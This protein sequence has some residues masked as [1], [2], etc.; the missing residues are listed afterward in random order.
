MTKLIE[1]I[2]GLLDTQFPEF[3]VSDNPNFVAF[4]KAYY[5]WLEDSNNGAVL[6][7]TKNLLAYK[8]IDSTTDQFIQYFINDFLP[9]FPSE[10]IA[11]QR[12]LVKFARE[13]YQTKGS[14]NSIKFLFRTLY[15]ED[16]E[17]FYP[18]DNILRASAGKWQ[19]PQSVRVILNSAYSES[20]NVGSSFDVALLNMRPALGSESNATCI[21]E[22]ALSTIDP[23]LG[24]EIVE[25]YVSN[26]SK[27]FSAE[28]YLVVEGAY[29]NT[30]SFTFKEKIIGSL[31]NITIN[32]N[33]KGLT[34]NGLVLNSN[35]SIAYPGDPV[36]IYGGL[37]NSPEA[38]K[39]IA[40]VNSV[41][42]GSISGVTV[43]SGG[44]GYTVNPNTIVT[45]TGSGSGANLIVTSVNNSILPNTIR[46]STDAIQY[47]AGARI[48]FYAPSYS[49]NLTAGFGN[50]TSTVNLNT[51]TY[52]ANTTIDNFYSQYLLQVVDG[53][54]ALVS[55]N[56]A[57]IDTYNSGTQIAT[58]RTPLGSALDSTSNV[59]LYAAE[60]YGLPNTAL[61]SN[62]L[63]GAG[64]T[65]T[66][67]NLS[68]LTFTPS[69]VN[70]YYNNYYLVV[71]GGT[72]A[73]ANPNEAIITSYNGTTKIATV[74]PPLGIALDGSSNVELYFSNQFSRIS[75][76]LSFLTLNVGSVTGIG[77][78]NGGYNFS[79]VPNISLSST[80]ETDFSSS[81][82]D[83]LVIPNHANTIQYIKDLGL[84]A[85]VTVLNGGTGY[86]STNDTIVLNTALGYGAEFSFTVNAT[87]TITSV[88]VTTPGEGYPYPV[89]SVPV[90]V[91]SATGFG[92]SL[93]A[94]GFNDGDK[95]SISVSDIGRINDFRLVSRGFDYQTAPKVSL[96]VLDIVTLTNFS[97]II[98]QEDDFV[99]QGVSP[100][101][102]TFIAYFD[103]FGSEYS[104]L[105]SNNS[106]R[107]YN[108]AGFIDTSQ[109]LV[110]SNTAVSVTPSI[111]TR[112]GD[113][114][115]R[116]NAQFLNG[117][118]EYPGHYINT[119]GQLSSDQYL[120]AN[121]KYHNYSYVVQVKESLNYFKSTLINILH[122]TGM[123]V[124]SDMLIQDEKT[125]NDKLTQNFGT[126]SLHTG[127]IS[128]SYST[129]LTLTGSGSH[130]AAEASV[131]DLITITD[132]TYP[133]ARSQTK[134]IKSILS[135][136][137]L[138]IESDLSFSGPGLLSFS[139]Y[140]SPANAARLN[141]S[142]NIYGTVIPGDNIAF[143]F[144]NTL[145]G[146]SNTSYNVHVATV[147]SDGSY[148][149]TTEGLNG[150][151]TNDPILNSNS[152]TYVV[153]PNSYTS[154]S[155]RIIKL[156]G[157]VT[158]I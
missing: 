128:Y 60:Y 98:W 76:T 34:Y 54:G 92:A 147:S 12:K 118:I 121:T 32:P 116:A 104:G 25:I 103:K 6:Y 93:V 144:G 14:E 63:I 149:T 4:I 127:V 108:Y 49:I 119:D 9:Y 27:A 58:L 89:S 42:L 51:S 1:T 5:Q 11:D 153:Y 31:S 123:Q 138:D 88:V 23:N 55:P 75:D 52:V 74:S 87:G 22:S 66:T 148:L 109:P 84:I 45:V 106:I 64:N 151:V 111:I 86:D 26:I 43:E 154:S 142:S 113:G 125:L 133:V 150:N 141:A 37:T 90:S 129:P 2:S 73:T 68:S 101:S 132:T 136:T 95:Y 145:P 47:Q 79:T 24:I 8:D 56:T 99:F 140:I 130:F 19:I 97:G 28:E 135:N 85:N 16:I 3:I 158:N 7:H 131:E 70:G 35:G 36:V 114:K 146:G 91:N 59:I 30:Q 53:T 80:Y 124:L 15:D 13:F 117:V 20:V 152:T 71:S 61:H 21:I 102:A 83:P 120:Q 143:V 65:T 18:K 72:G 67:V 17:V 139:T 78:I 137:S 44:W 112:Y 77:V 115:A 38:T 122:P 29:A 81:Y 69:A 100:S 156:H 110:F 33:Y 57:Y 107:L 48:G 41:S 82:L 126:A 10:I 62:N 155:Y 94:Y 39:A 40:Y 134:T 46:V 96:A 157:D 50:T 105:L